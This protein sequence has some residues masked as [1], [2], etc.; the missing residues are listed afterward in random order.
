MDIE[1]IHADFVQAVSIEVNMDNHMVSPAFFSIP[2]PMVGGS[3]M[4]MSPDLASGSTIWAVKVIK[5]G[6]LSRKDDMVEG[7]KKAINRKWKDWG[8]ILTGSQ[9]L[10]YRDPAWCLSVLARLHDS[11][12]SL[13]T[14]HVTLLRPDELLPI[15]DAIAVRDD[16]YA[17]V[18]PLSRE[19]PTGN[20]LL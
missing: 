4:G 19:V 5:Y 8:V 3:P 12:E 15:K 14:T 18:R 9:L 1:A 10:L 13:P 11:E 20:L 7:G 6:L 2:S 17:K 16:S